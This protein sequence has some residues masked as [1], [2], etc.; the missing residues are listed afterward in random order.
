MEKFIN[1][2]KKRP[3]FFGDE[4]DN[5]NFGKDNVS[6]YFELIKKAQ[7]KKQCNKINGI[8]KKITIKITD[9]KEDINYEYLEPD[10][11][12]P[13]RD[14]TKRKI[15]D[16][17]KQDFYLQFNETT[18][19]RDIFGDNNIDETI[20]DEEEESFFNGDNKVEGTTQC[21]VH[22]CSE[23]GE[24]VEVKFLQYK[25]FFYLSILESFPRDLDKDEET[26]AELIDKLK[27]DKN[28]PWKQV[29]NIELIYKN[30]VVGFRNGIKMPFIL[31]KFTTIYAFNRFKSWLK[32]EFPE[33][34]KEDIE[35]KTY[36][37]DWVICEDFT[38]HQI[39]LANSMNIQYCGWIKLPAG[40][41]KNLDPEENN[42][43]AMYVFEATEMIPEPM[44]KEIA[45]MITDCMDIEQ[46]RYDEQDAFPNATDPK[47]FIASICHC[48]EISDGSWEPIYYLFAWG[49]KI[50]KTI[51]DEQGNPLFNSRI[52]LKIYKTEADMLNG[53]AKWRKKFHPDVWY[54]WNTYGYDFPTLIRRIHTIQG[55]DETTKCFQRIGKCK[56]NIKEKPLTSSQLQANSLWLPKP[57][58]GEVAWDLLLFYKKD[59]TFKPTDYKL[60]T[61]ARE[62]LKMKKND[63]KPSEMKGLFY[64]T[65][66]ERAKLFAYNVQ[67][68]HITRIL[69]VYLLHAINDCRI[70]RI[71]M[72]F[73][74]AYGQQQKMFGGFQYAAQQLDYIIW[75]P[76]YHPILDDPI[77]SD[78]GKDSNDS[79]EQ[80][81]NSDVLSYF[82]KTQQEKDDS[83]NLEDDI[84]YWNNHLK[85]SNIK[86]SS[87]NGD[88]KNETLKLL[89]DNTNEMNASERLQLL[90]Q[91]QKIN[92]VFQKGSGVST[93]GLEVNPE[94][95]S[96]KELSRFGFMKTKL[97][98]KSLKI[99]GNDIETVMNLKRSRQQMMKT[100][101]ALKH[102]MLTGEDIKMEKIVRKKGKVGKEKGFSGGY[103]IEPIKGLYH[104]LI[105]LDFSALYPSIMISHRI[106]SDNIV[107]DSRF[108][109]CEENSYLDIE[110][111]HKRIVRFSQKWIGVMNTHVK[112]LLDSREVA[113]EI[114]KKY[115]TRSKFLISLLG[116]IGRTCLPIETNP[117]I[118][119]KDKNIGDWEIWKT[120]SNYFDNQVEWIN[121]IKDCLNEEL[122]GLTKLLSPLNW[123][124]KQNFISEIVKSQWKDLNDFNIPKI[125][126]NQLIQ[127]FNEWSKLA[128]DKEKELIENIA[129]YFVFISNFINKQKDQQ[130]T[131]TNVLIAYHK[132]L[133]SEETI[134]N[135]KQNSLKLAANSSFG[136]QGAGGGNLTFTKD[137]HIERRGVFTVIPVPA[138]VTYIGRKT[139]ITSQGLI[140]RKYNGKE[141]FHFL[142]KINII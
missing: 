103:V 134:Y 127:L 81:N 107:L 91:N 99:G 93:Y 87:I 63:V 61:V 26:T 37:N 13:Q 118:N 44:R 47:D 96:G 116:K 55:I 53:W 20:Y 11:E 14:I 142:K 28:L 27:K 85:D 84:D 78:E 114:M 25:P 80:I 120:N 86:L 59:Q 5:S 36:Q 117:F 46:I 42:I 69:M 123:D 126:G 56:V 9:H 105:I 2:N 113:K 34:T 22:C 119:N 104:N 60:D 108:A 23:T 101:E 92:N 38:Q 95:N 30:P 39:K 132:W 131:T 129:H 16:T 58:A 122:V 68:V 41:Y 40:T 121:I 64:G 33:P 10:I 139:I 3:I 90:E 111:N 18:I 43:S 76:P 52:I 100:K 57:L 65:A 24:S 136:A 48:L 88:N 19:L 35:R 110:F 98:E 74:C 140:K 89:M 51:K 15:I 32:R 102:K 70:N 71:P 21:Y 97:E 50:D 125:F 137:G 1:I 4:D 109:N 54:G 17:E 124:K 12:I 72:N 67:D 106:A 83:S 112:N 66:Q 133:S 29:D 141:I 130:K 75:R 94:N 45:P 62:K 82:L 115:A 73:I 138:A 128:N 79:N 8:Q 77:G 49:G 31:F 135:S 7:D 6:E